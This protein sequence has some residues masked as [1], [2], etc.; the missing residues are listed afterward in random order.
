MTA[1]SEED[2]RQTGAWRLQLRIERVLHQ[3]KTEHQDDG[4]PRQQGMPESVHGG[5]EQNR[6]QCTPGI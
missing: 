2:D 3:E 1:W 5:P 6:Y 4:R